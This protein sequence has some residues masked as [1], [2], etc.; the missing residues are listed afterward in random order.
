MMYQDITRR[1]YTQNCHAELVSRFSRS[2]EGFTLIELIVVVLIIGVLAAV[3]MPMYKHAALKSRFSTVMPMAKS[4]A[5]AQEVY[6]LGNGDYAAVK[7][8]L[9]ITPVDAENTIVKLSGEYANADA[10][11]EYV[12]AWR[13]DFPNA[14][15][16]MYQEHSPMFAG[17]IHCEAKAD[18]A[19]A[20][21]LCKEGLGGQDVLGERSLQGTGYKTYI[22]QGGAGDGQFLTAL[23][24]VAATVCEG[25][26]SCVTDEDRGTVTAQTCTPYGIYGGGTPQAECEAVIYNADGK[27][28]ERME[29]RCRLENG[30]CANWFNGG[31]VYD[32]DDNIIR[33]MGCNGSSDKGGDC[34]Y[35]PGYTLYIDNNF[36]TYC[37]NS[38]NSVNWDTLECAS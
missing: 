16:I 5:N 29:R 3:A 9:D 23:E 37:G 18:D 34:L 22:L 28:N 6:Y 33:M 35:G 24:K 12:A 1:G 4:V 32:E 20:M 10:N 31:T 19:E 36:V 25:V 7:G 8:N 15:Y 13:T 30:V 14:R 27:M 26:D 38:Y 2:M 17:N 21:W 11:Y